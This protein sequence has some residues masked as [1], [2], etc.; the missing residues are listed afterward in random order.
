MKKTRI[1]ALILA[2]LLLA[3]C[4][5]EKTDDTAE[6]DTAETAADTVTEENEAEYVFPE[7]DCKGEKFTILN[8]YT[9]WNFT[10]TILVEESTGDTL[11]DTILNANLRVEEEFNVDLAVYEVLITDMINFYMNSVMA[12]EDAYKYAITPCKIMGNP[13]AYDAVM[14][15]TQFD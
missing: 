3:S 5:S 13:D 15:L 7:L 8:D 2:G 9:D 6:T 1:L 11:N 4:G 12:G 10:T 14:E